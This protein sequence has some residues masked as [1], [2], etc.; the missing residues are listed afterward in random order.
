M[1]QYQ[2]PTEQKSRAISIQD[3][4]EELMKMI[5]LDAVV[6]LWFIILL[7]FCEC[8]L[9]PLSSHHHPSYN[10]NEEPRLIQLQIFYREE[11]PRLI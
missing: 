6:V 2:L 3:G 4:D 5:M 8:V 7:C 9:L 1:T 10:K 11:N